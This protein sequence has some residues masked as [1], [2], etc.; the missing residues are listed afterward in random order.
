LTSPAPLTD[1]P[2]WSFADTPLITKPPVPASTSESC[3]VVVVALPKTTKEAPDLEVVADA[4]RE[5]GL[6]GVI[7]QSGMGPI[8]ALDMI[9]GHTGKVSGGNRFMAHHTGF[10]A[11]TRTKALR[12][13]GFLGVAVNRLDYSLWATGHKPD[14][15]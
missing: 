15:G 5:K 11:D 6:D 7:Y 12:A 3:T 10:T 1:L 9:Y 13:R 8:T 2:D 14:R 4:I